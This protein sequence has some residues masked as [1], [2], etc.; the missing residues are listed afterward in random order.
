MTLILLGSSGFIGS[1]IFDVLVQDDSDFIV[2]DRNADFYHARKGP[3]YKINKNTL[4][5]VS[6]EITV[7]N[8]VGNAIGTEQSILNANYVYPIKVL[9]ALSMLGVK[10]RWIQASSYFQNYKSSFGID[11]NF[12]A[13]TK[14]QIVTEL[15]SRQ[16]IQNVE[17]INLVLPH[18]TGIGEPERRLIPQLIKA[19]LTKQFIFLSSGLSVLPIVGVEKIANNVVEIARNRAFQGGGNVHPTTYLTVREIAEIILK[20]QFELAL[21]GKLPDRMN[22]FLTIDSI[23]LPRAI[24]DIS[25]LVKILAA[26]ENHIGLIN[27]N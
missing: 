1:K 9:D 18:V 14:Q 27:T 13:K 3:K 11:K 25:D 26:M 20:D 23:G 17:V 5:S 10:I 6:E 12:Y 8:M 24:G 19:K 21:F 16:S 4:K 22:E 15:Y 7:V 2:C